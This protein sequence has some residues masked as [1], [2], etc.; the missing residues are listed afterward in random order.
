VGS[1]RKVVDVIEHETRI[2]EAYRKTKKR[3]AGETILMPLKALLLGTRI[4]K[5]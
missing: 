2:V 1:P 3:P 5:R 4:R